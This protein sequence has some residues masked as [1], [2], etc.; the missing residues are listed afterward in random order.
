MRSSFKFGYGSKKTTSKEASRLSRAFKLPIIEPSNEKK[1]TS[2]T[3]NG[4]CLALKQPGLSSSDLTKPWGEEFAATNYSQM[5]TATALESIKKMEELAKSAEDHLEALVISTGTPETFKLASTP[6]KVSTGK[7]IKKAITNYA[8]SARKIFFRAKIQIE[9]ISN[10]PKESDFTFSSKSKILIKI[11]TAEHVVVQAEAEDTQKLTTS[12]EKTQGLNPTGKSSTS[13]RKHKKAIKKREHATKNTLISAAKM[14]Q[15]NKRTS[16]SGK[17]LLPISKKFAAWEDI[18]ETVKKNGDK[19]YELN[20]DYNKVLKPSFVDG[21]L[22]ATVKPLAAAL[23]LSVEQL[24]EGQIKYAMDIETDQNGTN[25]LC[26]HCKRDPTGASGH[27]TCENCY[28][29]W[30]DERTE[31]L[32]FGD[33]KNL[34]R[35]FPFHVPCSDVEDSFASTGDSMKGI[36][37]MPI[38]GF[39]QKMDRRLFRAKKQWRSF[40]A[41]VPNWSRKVRAA[42]ND[43]YGWRSLRP[44]KYGR[45]PKLWGDLLPQDFSPIYDKYWPK[46]A[47]PDRFYGVE[48]NYGNGRRLRKYRESTPAGARFVNVPYPDQKPFIVPPIWYKLSLNFGEKRKN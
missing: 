29:F 28:Y 45:K 20:F 11:P 33:A 16:R 12:G 39:W 36:C 6:A 8:K 3:E 27:G 30:K 19:G 15:T 1:T 7:R 10:C 31:F 48:V 43:G 14:R 26:A 21:W 34:K 35:E 18:K 13:P 25:R 5:T 38:Y 2:Q 32:K 44:N 23:S 9:A 24:V 17:R 42:A 41:I 46:D 47:G 4:S 37:L 40:R 22:D